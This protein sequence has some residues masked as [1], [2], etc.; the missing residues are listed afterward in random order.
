MDTT[1]YDWL[2]NWTLWGNEAK[3]IYGSLLIFAGLMV[4]FIVLRRVVLR[5]LER[6]AKVTRS[7][8]DDLVIDVT[9]KITWPFYALIA[10]T[11]ALKTLFLP[12]VWEKG[13]NAILLLV[14]TAEVILMLQRLLDYVIAQRVGDEVDRP[15]DSMLFATG[16]FIKGTLWILGA[17]LIVSN[18]G[19]NVTSLI[20]GLGVSGIIVAFALQ[21]VLSDIFSSL[22][23]HLDKPFQLGDFII[24]KDIRGTVEKIGLK[25]TRIRA[26][27][28]EQI[29]MP[30]QELT[31][32]QVK[33]YRNME[34]RRVQFEFRVALNTPTEKLKKLPAEIEKVITD[35]EQT[36][37]SRAHLNE[38]H[39]SAWVFEVVYFLED[40]DYLLYMDTQQAVWLGIKD[41][42][43]KNKIVL[44]YPTRTV[45]LEK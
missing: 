18:L 29:I 8:F 39:E 22:S 6:L 10:G 36:T 17:L 40:S 43:D 34:R 13:L 2:W 15:S 14:V 7:G 25:S 3:S 16:D 23:I 38:L 21:N 41:C 12:A 26:L 37:F 30:N 1:Q 5:R 20:A 27:S 11:I 9:R 19:I 45:V 44:P 33:N 32:S 42:L 24:V 28:G 31:N 35:I 4:V